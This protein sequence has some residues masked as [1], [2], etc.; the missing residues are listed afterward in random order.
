LISLLAA[1]GFFGLDQ[2]GT[3]LECPFGTDCNDFPILKMGRSLCDELDAIMRTLRREQYH[4]RLV[5][6]PDEQDFARR[7]AKHLGW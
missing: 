1:I 3:E 5:I 7:T 4:K 6:S 2:V